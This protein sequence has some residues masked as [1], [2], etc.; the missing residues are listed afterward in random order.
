MLRS[1]FSGISG[2]RAHQQM[3]DITSNNIANVNT[4][5]FKAST[6]VFQ[7][8]LSQLI[9][10]S[11]GPQA[12]NGGT[13]PAAIGLGVRLGAITT[14]FGQGSAQ[15]TG[16]ST[17]LMINGD[18]FFVVE[19]AGERMFTRA[20]AF[21]FDTE[22]RL[23][24][25]T[26]AVVQ[27]WGANNGVVDTNGLAKDVQLPI[28]TLYPPQ[29]STKSLFTGNLPGNTTS[30]VPITTAIKGYDKA[31]NELTL[32]VTFTKNTPT[33]WGVTVSDGTSTSSDTIDF[34][35]GGGTPDKTSVT[36]TRSAPASNIVFDVSKITSYAGQN[37]LAP[38]SQ[39]GS[40]LGSL[41]TFTISKDGLVI[42]VFSNGLKQTLAQLTMASFNNPPGLD[43]VGESM[44]RNTVN[45]GEPQLGVAGSGGR[46]L[47]QG[48]T[49]EMS[50][51]DLGQEFTNL[52]VAQRGFQANSKVISASD[53]L[54]QE[55][56]NMKR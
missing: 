22:G 12:G 48:S 3:L 47:L 1:L 15:V 28:S 44:Y 5:G 27:G 32:S 8:T 50:N 10:P 41:N 16:R 52:I 14:N 45:S 42:G 33:N 31:G 20:G 24:N 39:N 53:E 49:L 26:G 43:K 56:V 19:N 54:L 40:A 36:L 6:A 25:P 7:D 13:N 18:G 9:Q 34:G 38:E 37:T 4:T 29:E 21:S 51:V 17:D 30:P 2:L 23:V 11:S 35:A 46:G 55:L